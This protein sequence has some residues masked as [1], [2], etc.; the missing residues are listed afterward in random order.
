MF[1]STSDI[2]WNIGVDPCIAHEFMQLTCKEKVAA[3]ET[4]DAVAILG[5]TPDE[6]LDSVHTPGGHREGVE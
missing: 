4:M 3:S 2:L 1:A 5:D 6:F